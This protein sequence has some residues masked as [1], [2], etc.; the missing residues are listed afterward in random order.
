MQHGDKRAKG[1]HGRGGQEQEG[2]GR[3]G[4]IDALKGAGILLVVFGHL[5]E[6]PSGQSALLHTLYVGI[7]TFHMPLFVFLSGI[8]AKRVLSGTDYQKIIWSL[9]V[10]LVVFQIIYRLVGGWTDW[11]HYPPLA[12]YWILWFVASLIGWRLLLPLFASR[13]GLLVALLG[14]VLA[15]FDHSIGYALSAS[16]TIYFLPFFILGHLYG[17]RT[18]DM[19]QR[20]RIAFAGLFVIAMIAVLFWWQ[21]GLDAAALTGS[22]DYDGAPP[23]ELYPGAGRVLLMLIGVAALIGFSALVPRMWRPLEWLGRRSLAIYLIHGLLIM[24]FVW[25]GAS[26]LVPDVAQLPVYLLL[27]VIISAVTALGD[28]PL[29]RFFRPPHMP[30]K[31]AR[32]RDFPGPAE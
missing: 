12:P 30:P 22:H 2:R 20:H 10:P 5:I 3:F 16:R 31:K 15:G 6:Q 26:Q 9:F 29:R 28:G 27:A 23:D 14:A 7:Y 1:G 17:M 21:N 13:I 24:V 25:S 18:I 8:F 19:A 4:H 32:P 11:N